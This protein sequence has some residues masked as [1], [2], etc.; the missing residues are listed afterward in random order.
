MKN[1]QSI[2]SQM[3][4]EEKAALCTGASPWTTT[5]GGTPGHP[6]NDRVRWPAWRSPRAGCQLR[7]R[8]KACPPPAFPPHPVSLPP[9]MWTC[10]AKWARR[11]PRNAI[12]LNVD[13]LLGPGANMKRSPL[14]GRNFEYFS[15]DPYL[16]GEMA[17]SLI[18]GIQSQGRGHF[19]QALCR[20]QPGIPALQHQRRG[21]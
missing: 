2:I 20:Q 17:A 1:I 18:N 7:W 6:G 10:S 13:V 5:P 21:G 8:S 11:W 12:A 19:A 16:A 9:G 3:T 15:E 14:G 4:L